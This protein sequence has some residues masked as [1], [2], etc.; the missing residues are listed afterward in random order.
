MIDGYN[1]ADNIDEE[2]VMQKRK[3]IIKWTKQLYNQDRYLGLKDTR[4]AYKHLSTTEARML[5]MN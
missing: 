5:K 4:Q 2:K 3:G 1:S